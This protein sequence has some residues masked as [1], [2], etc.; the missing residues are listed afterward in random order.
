MSV[1][2]SLAMVSVVMKVA[3]QR[4]KISRVTFLRSSREG[5]QMNLV[6]WKLGKEGK[7]VEAQ[8]EETEKERRK[9]PG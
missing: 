4:D 6:S 8:E 5:A 7:E 2:K 9:G 3:A 1:V